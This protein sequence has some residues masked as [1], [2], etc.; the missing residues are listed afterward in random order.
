MSVVFHAVELYTLKLLKTALATEA[1]DGINDIG[2]FDDLSDEQWTDVKTELQQQ[3][4]L[5][6]PADIIPS[7]NI[8]PDEKRAYTL[9]IARNLK[10]FHDLMIEQVEICNLLES[11]KIPAVILKGAAAAASYTRPEYRQMGD[12]DILAEPEHIEKAVQLLRECG[13]KKGPDNGRHIDFHSD[14][15]IDIELH[16]YFSTSDDRKQNEVLDQLV[17]DGIS[18]REKLDVCGYSVPMLPTLQNGLVL[19]AHVNQHLG[20]GLGMRQIIDWMMYVDR[21]LDDEAWDLEFRDAAEAI[22]MRTLAETTTLLC[23]RHLGLRNITWCDQADSELADELLAYI[24]CKG[25]FGRKGERDSNA[26][27]IVMHHFRDP[28]AAF[29]YLEYG[30]I[31]NWKAAQ[32]YKIL[33]PF[34][35]IYQIARLL[36]KGLQRNAGIGTLTD[37]LKQSRR[38]VAFLEK[39]GVMRK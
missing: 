18:K 16:R 25:N 39:L 13:Y 33:R 10:S 17:F 14:S 35:W 30:G 5:A 9:G 29:R 28:I 26:T 37:E 38:E 3:A 36:H 4:V 22:G 19:L 11:E 24:F 20:G 8:S 21:Y 2:E 23:K 6:I 34:A 1:E 7:L 12:I 15:G 32:K 27:V 31:S